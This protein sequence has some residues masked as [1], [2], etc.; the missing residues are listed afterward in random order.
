M[1][2]LIVFTV[3][4]IFLAAKV[5]AQATRPDLAVVVELM[6]DRKEEPTEFF[7]HLSNSTNYVS[8]LVPLSV[9]ATGYARGEKTTVQKGW[10]MA[11]S[12]VASSLIT[13]GLKY[14]IRRNR[15][16]TT[17]PYIV[18]ASSGGGPS[19]PSGHTSEAFATATSL[20]LAFHKWWVAVPAYAWAGSVGYSRMYLGVHY[21]SDV[22]AGALV[23]AGSAWLMYKAN[24]WLHRHKAGNMQPV[25]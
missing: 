21:P 1:K 19:F 2:Y 17:D 6:E 7:Q 5:K 11:E 3:F 10:Y 13:W 25:L 4:P 8:M 12:L 15:P 23:G 24:Q 16:F 9:L 20:T 18:P 22:A 14:T